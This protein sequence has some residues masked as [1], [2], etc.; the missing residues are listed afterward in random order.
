MERLAQVA[1]NLIGNAVQHG[2]RDD[3][4]QV[5]LDGTQADTVVLSVVNAGSIAPDVLPHIFDP[6]RRGPREPEPNEGSGPRS[7]HRAA[8]RPCAPGT[9][10][11]RVRQRRD[12]RCSA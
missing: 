11:R 5:R 2:D 12:R 7:L 3:G 1:S 10:R 8:D 9:R 6:F 4:V